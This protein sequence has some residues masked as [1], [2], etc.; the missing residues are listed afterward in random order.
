MSPSLDWEEVRQFLINQKFIR[1]NEIDEDTF[2]AICDRRTKALPGTLLRELSVFID[3]YILAK[4]WMK[5]TP[6][7]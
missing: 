2:D 3:G 7:V 1:G 5:G 6:S 4:I